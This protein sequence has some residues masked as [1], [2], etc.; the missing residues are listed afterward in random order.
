MASG[1][2]PETL[3]TFASASSVWTSNG[4]LP[5][6]SASLGPEALLTS[7]AGWF[8]GGQEPWAPW[9]V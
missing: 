6:P 8:L 2:V 9:G 3:W 7:W 5:N 4:H 1:T